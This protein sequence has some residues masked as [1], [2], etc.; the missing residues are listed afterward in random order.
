MTEYRLSNRETG[1]EFKVVRIDREAGKIILEGPRG[2][3]FAEVYD[4]AELKK[5]GYVLR[6][7][8]EG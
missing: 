2:G 3:Q 4:P 6:K 7:V 1:R 5:R 8:E